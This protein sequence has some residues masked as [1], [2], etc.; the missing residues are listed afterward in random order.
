M[1][2]WEINHNFPVEVLPPEP[3]EMEE[4]DPE[5][6][7]DVDM[8]SSDD[9]DERKKWRKMVRA[10]EKDP[11]S[12]GAFE[13]A[14]H[15]FDLKGSFLESERYAMSQASNPCLEIEGLG[16][17]GL[18]LSTR[19]ARVLMSNNSPV[20]V[21]VLEIP[22]EKVRFQ[23]PDWDA[24]LQKQGGIVCT[25]LA[26]KPVQPSFRL[27]NLILQSPGSESMN[28]IVSTA[29]AIGTFLV[30][31]PSIFTGAQLECTHGVQ[32]KTIDFSSK[33]KHLTSI[34]A[35]YSAVTIAQVA[36]SSGYRLS[37]T[38][39]ILQPEADPLS[40]PSLPDTESGPLALQQAMSEWKANESGSEPE[41]VAY[42][43]QRRYPLNDFTLQELGGS[44]AVLVAN[45]VRLAE[46]LECQLC[47]VQLKLYQSLYGQY[48]GRW[49]RV[50]PRQI[51]DLETEDEL[52]SLE[53]NAV[54]AHGVPVQISGFDFKCGEY[55]N[56]E[57]D[58][59]QPYQREYETIFDEKIRVDEVYGRTLFI[60][61]PTRDD[62]MHPLEIR[63][64]SKYAGWALQS[65]L[66]TTP[67]A[68]ENMLVDSVRADLKENTFKDEDRE[69]VT[70][71]LC[72]C[73][74]RWSDLAMLLTTLETN[75]VAAN[76][77]LIG[78]DNCV[79]AYRVFGWD[80]L[81]SF[82]D[83]AVQKDVS[84]PRRQ[85]LV[86]QFGQ[87]ARETADAEVEAWC[88]EQQE[89]ILE[90]LSRSS[91][92]EV[93]WLLGLATNHGVDFMN[94]IVYPQ[95]DAQQLESD[96]WVHFVRRLEGHPTSAELGLDFLQQC[97]QQAVDNLPAFPTCD[98]QTQPATSLIMDVLKLSFDTKNSDLWDGI[99]D[100]MEQAARGGT[101]PV[102]CPPWKYYLELV[103]SLDAYLSL[104]EGTSAFSV[105]AFFKQAVLSI[106]SGSPKHNQP[107]FSPCPFTA[108]NL[109]TLVVAIKRAG[110]LS[111]LDESNRQVILAGRDSESL[112]T[113]VVHL[114][115]ELQPP[116]D[117]PAAYA[118]LLA[119]VRQAID[120]FDTQRLHVPEAKGKP[121]LSVDDMIGMLKFCFEVGAQ[122]ESQ[123]LL[124]RFVSPPPGISI[125]HHVSKVLAPFLPALRDY[126][127]SQTI[128]LQ[129]DP[130]KKFTA[131]IVKAFAGSVMSQTPKD[132]N[133][134]AVEDIGCY[135]PKCSDCKTVRAFFES[136]DQTIS[137][138]RAA[139]LREHIEKQLAVPKSLG[140]RLA[141]DKDHGLGSPH[142]LEIIKPDHM[143]V[144][145]LWSQNS[146][147]GKALL[148]LLGDERAQRRILSPDYEKVLAQIFERN[149]SGTKR[150]AENDQMDTPAKKARVSLS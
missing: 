54:D 58:D 85:A 28:S 87:A 146:A 36:V 116:P 11:A 108:E 139:K 17:V 9:G 112:K 67:S 71:A 91:V 74:N 39:D 86:T 92:T 29:G 122:A 70:R 140:V 149:S 25:A 16:P 144:A 114:V 113:L 150:A 40:V 2:S 8:S 59:V 50:N 102:K 68:R 13:K 15:M 51:T 148:A 89:Q 52:T 30:V 4:D 90:F 132:L 66:S 78:T 134:Y 63:Y 142:R 19:V 45:L 135:A 18:P 14:L 143:T 98:V 69:A 47:V 1:K 121:L 60:L 101:F 37:L 73:A 65:S 55:L 124:L 106:L 105:Q 133:L 127:A 147:R 57:I 131:S 128:E 46:E 26:G 61:W 111:F 41:L 34:L 136:D 76:L 100:K 7:E 6:E 43:L 84:N 35:A 3:S 94:E 23:N 22:A 120:V 10:R 93:E 103:R 72:T 38:Y 110:G 130:F 145:G 64:A 83:E 53:V 88:R 107:S 82:F 99:F 79:A 42:F 137:L 5:F 104:L 20:D 117:D 141:L 95:L 138:P 109:S 115:A 118:V 119:V 81:K 27:R 32:S 62:L 21:G 129:T 96:F 56:G 77:G 12:M 97:V 75:H 126:L 24:W 80:A 48:D 123:Y 31:L 44:D 49:D 125:P 33:S